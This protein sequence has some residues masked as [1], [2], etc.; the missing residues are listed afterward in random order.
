M[1]RIDNSQYNY[2]G[3]Q[4]CHII[5]R[6][7]QKFVQTFFYVINYSGQIIA[8]LSIWQILILLLGTPSIVFRMEY[9]WKLPS[10]TCGAILEYPL[11]QFG[12][13]SIRANGKVTN[14]IMFFKE[15]PYQQWLDGRV[16]A[17]NSTPE[18]PAP[19]QA[20]LYK[21]FKQA[22]LANMKGA[23][24]VPFIDYDPSQEG[25]GLSYLDDENTERLETLVWTRLGHLHKSE[26][27]NISENGTLTESVT[28]GEKRGI[29][30]E[31]NRLETE[32]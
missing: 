29:L 10:I 24:K 31:D 18:S 11:V 1:S 7:H 25:D 6:S 14:R 17:F 5:P 4:A 12:P 9:C 30:E 3:Q 21:H 15:G 22:V 26:E 28:L 19:P 2:Y 8:C 32:L 23:G 20:F 16:V 13:P 27:D